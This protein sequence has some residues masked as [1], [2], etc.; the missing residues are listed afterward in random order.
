MHK[1][2]SRLTLRSPTCIHSLGMTPIASQRRSWTT[3]TATWRSSWPAQLRRACV[4]VCRS[5]LA[6]DSVW[7]FEWRTAHAEVALVRDRFGSFAPTTDS[8]RR[9]RAVRPGRTAPRPGALDHSGSLPA[10]RVAR[11]GP[12][13][14]PGFMPE[15]A[16]SARI[17]TTPIETAP[18]RAPPFH[19]DSTDSSPPA[20][21]PTPHPDVTA[22]RTLPGD[23][24]G[25]PY[26]L[27]R[28]ARA[29]VSQPRLPATRDPRGDVYAGASQRR[30]EAESR[31]LAKAAASSH[32]L[33]QSASSRTRSRRAAASASRGRARTRDTLIRADDADPDESLRAQIAAGILTA[34]GESVREDDY[35]YT[36][37]PQY[38]RRVVAGAAGMARP[39]PPARGAP[40]HA[41]L[42]S[43]VPAFGSAEYRESEDGEEAG[44]AGAWRPEGELGAIFDRLQVG[45]EATELRRALMESRAVASA[46][47]ERIRIGALDIVSGAVHGGGST[48]AAVALPATSAPLSTLTRGARGAAAVLSAAAAEAATG[49]TTAVSTSMPAAHPSLVP[50][51]PARVHSSETRPP[52][53]PTTTT[54][55][56]TPP[57]AG[58]TRVATGAST[59]TP[60]LPTSGA[61]SSSSFGPSMAL[62]SARALDR[63]LTHHAIEPRD[64]AT[65][66]PAQLGQAMPADV[67]RQLAALEAE[68]AST[69]GLAE[70][71]GALAG[72]GAEGQMLLS[73]ASPPPAA[74]VTSHSSTVGAGAETASFAPDSLAAWADMRSTNLRTAEPASVD[75]APAPAPAR[76]VGGSTG[77]LG[78]GGAAS[79]QLEAMRQLRE[80]L[81]RVAGVELG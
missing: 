28:N 64:F 46:T 34:P 8:L 5:V 51:H 27:L 69:P 18:G 4:H 15:A 45:V 19:W 42:S 74:R 23:A 36:P 29:A 78:S 77:A 22:S 41:M 14:A 60:L 73:R 63:T 80:R 30:S 50:R 48:A 65:V 70:W 55:T 81:S 21:R 9:D 72:H 40:A 59:M 2:V 62:P 32:P 61:S 13:P 25:D 31:F 76:A 52:P 33:A 58:E 66:Q 53:Q 67:R 43:S 24:A 17:I 75:P 44:R 79:K 3:S 47:A 54:T 6:L 11:P 16:A 68:L 38:R 35:T 39:R 12:T 26:G 37:D 10:L 57:I 56:V 71:A 1:R 7:G 20:Y 49:T